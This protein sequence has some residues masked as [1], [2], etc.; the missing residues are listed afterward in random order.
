M[1]LAGLN[2]LHL[3]NGST[4]NLRGWLVNTLIHTPTVERQNILFLNACIFSFLQAG[5]CSGRKNSVL[6]MKKKCLVLNFVPTMT[7]NISE[8]IVNSLS[9]SFQ[10]C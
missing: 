6:D 10:I 7:F 5:M 2:H 1:S 4:K 9:L 3:H 8:K